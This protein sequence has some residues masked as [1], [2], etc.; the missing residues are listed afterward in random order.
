MRRNQVNHFTYSSFCIAS[1]V[2]EMSKG[3]SAAR[4]NTYTNK[5]QTA[6]GTNLADFSTEDTY[7]NMH[8]NRTC[9]M[10]IKTK[11]LHSEQ[12][13]S[14]QS[15]F[16]AWEMLLRARRTACKQGIAPASN[17]SQTHTHSKKIKDPSSQCKVVVKGKRE[18][19]VNFFGHSLIAITKQCQ[20]SSLWGLHVRHQLK[21]PALPGKNTKQHL[22]EELINTSP[23]I[24]G[25]PVAR[26]LCIH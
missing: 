25:L 17:N 4:S 13:I 15:G 20:E 18:T 8:F 12:I 21:M 10:L 7:K 9:C 5:L 6:T 11:L 3:H 2:Q 16:Q 23:H 26:V 24:T 19:T 22:A 1:V 14:S